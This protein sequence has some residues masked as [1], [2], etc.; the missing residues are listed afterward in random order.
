MVK[1]L[2]GN[3][4]QEKEGILIRNKWGFP[5]SPSFPGYPDSWKRRVAGET[6]KKLEYPEN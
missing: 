3:I 1:Y 5:P 6:G 4:K 2:D